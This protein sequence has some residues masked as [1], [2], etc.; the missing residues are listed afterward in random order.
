MIQLIII[1]GKQSHHMISIYVYLCPM[2]FY[3]INF[4]QLFEVWVNFCV[5]ISSR[6]NQISLQN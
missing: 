6:S 5:G 4:K 3:T 2:F 1:L